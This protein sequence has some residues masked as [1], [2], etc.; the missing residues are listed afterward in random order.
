VNLPT[1]IPQ[2]FSADGRY[3]WD[4]A[5]WQPAVSPDGR[6]RWNGTQW[7]PIGRQRRKI[8]I[9]GGLIIAAALLLIVWFWLPA[10]FNFISVLVHP[11]S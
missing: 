5:R 1:G 3:W 4:G 11:P 6:W 7:Q 8:G 10:I 2:Q 9:G